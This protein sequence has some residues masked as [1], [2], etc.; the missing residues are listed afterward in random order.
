MSILSAIEA[1]AP[2]QYYRLN[3]LTG[4]VAHDS[5]SAGYNGAF[6]VG[7]QLGLPGPEAGTYSAQFNRLLKMAALL[8]SLG[9]GDQTILFWLASQSR[10]NSAI[11]GAGDGFAG[12]SIPARGWNVLINSTAG[13]GWVGTGY[14]IGRNGVQSGLGGT[15]PDNDWHFVAATLTSG[16]V[17][18]L[19]VDGTFV[20][21]ASSLTRTIPNSTDRA[22]IGAPGT[23]VALQAA[24]FAWFTKVLTAAEILGVYNARA[25][26]QQ[27]AYLAGQYASANNNIYGTAGP[28]AA[29]LSDIAAATA[30][31]QGSVE[32]VSTN[33]GL[34]SL[35]ADT[36]K[37][38]V[39][40]MSPVLDT[41][42][43][44]AANVQTIVGAVQTVA[45]DIS[46]R[47]LRVVNPTFADIAKGT[48]FDCTGDGSHALDCVGIYWQITVVPDGFGYLIGEPREY[49]NRVGWFTYY[50]PDR[51]GVDN[52][53][54]DTLSVR[55]SEG[56]YMFT[57]QLPDTLY[58]HVQPGCTIRVW[59]L[60]LG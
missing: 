59:P 50:D 49:F 28:D 47:L 26:P 55:I 12:G 9:T 41:V 6:D 35:V 31:V 32:T 34:L 27:V 37:T 60:V 18:N 11:A 7:V 2:D 29:T 8:S 21:T 40:A 22:W 42:H 51:L 4:V 20:A 14:N 16:G 17:G 56:T 33:L 19:Y 54:V 23:N 52:L 25:G 30:T 13:N 58:W 57:Q 36:I 43:T 15:T 45:E 53:P 10:P 38:T 3:E 39:L 1:L 44:I 5:G 24:H 46:T 48:P